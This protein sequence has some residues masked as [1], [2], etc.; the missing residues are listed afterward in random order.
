MFPMGMP[1]LS[2]ERLADYLA[3]SPEAL[4]EF[5]REYKSHAFPAD[6]CNLFDYSSRDA[7][8]ELDGQGYDEDI[9]NRIVGGCL[10]TCEV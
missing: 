10:A 4:A 1:T 5:E 7:V 8:S 2:K 3:M 9:V 6:N